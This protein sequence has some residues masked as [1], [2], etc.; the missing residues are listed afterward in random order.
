MINDKL[1]EFI[2]SVIDRQ[3]ISADDVEILRQDILANGIVH[4]REAETLLALDRTVK[5]DDAWRPALTALVVDFVSGDTGQTGAVAGG[6]TLWLAAVLDVSGPT[7]TAMSIAY[8]ILSQI[9]HV[10]AA[11][12]DFIMRGRQQARLGSLAA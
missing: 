11:L 7:E 6:D 10:D 1:H 9:R 3:Y 2:E 8:A 5:A 12:L 4:R